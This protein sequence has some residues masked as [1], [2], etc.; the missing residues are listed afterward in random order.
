MILLLCF[1]LLYRGYIEKI[2][3]DRSGSYSSLP[4]VYLLN[5]FSDRLIELNSIEG[6][7]LVS[8]EDSS[9]VP[10]VL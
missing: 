1:R 2:N 8:V 10:Q 3:D 4:V 6:R 5:D 7:A 9:R